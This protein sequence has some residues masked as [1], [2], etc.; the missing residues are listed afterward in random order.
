LPPAASG[1]RQ[2][3]RGAHQDFVKI[4]PTAVKNVDP[5]LAR[6]TLGLPKPPEG[7]VGDPGREIGSREGRIRTIGP[8][9][10]SNPEPVS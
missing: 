10:D 3:S 4:A 6:D 2:E 5:A 8:V 7:G 9:G 1:P